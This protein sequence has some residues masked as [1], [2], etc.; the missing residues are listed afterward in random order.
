M[1]RLIGHKLSERLGQPCI[2]ESRPGASGV[3]ANIAV[4]NAPADGHTLLLCNSAFLSNT[5]LQDKVAYKMPDFAPIC[6]LAL[7]PIALGISDSLAVTSLAQF[8]ALAKTR[9]GKMFYASYG[10]G[11]GGHFVGELFNMAAK[12]NVVHVAYKGE[13][14][15]LLEVLSGQVQSAFISA[16]GASRYPGRIRALAIANSER[17]PSYPDVPTFAELGYPEVDMLGWAAL[18]API[19]TPAAI[20]QMLTRQISEIVLLPDVNAK[21]AELG[22]DTVGWDV[23]RTNSFLAVQLEV[24]RKLVALGRVKI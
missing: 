3:L 16:G 23:P 19:K 21:M 15:A 7:T 2:V 20:V 14:P 5:L 12:L 1:M 22:F 10:P 9:P 4:A 11:S 6:M 8:V 17:S 13:T 18:M 24:T